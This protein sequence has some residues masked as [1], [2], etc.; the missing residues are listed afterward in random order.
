VQRD[1]RISSDPM[2]HDRFVVPGV[3]E[4]LRTKHARLRAAVARSGSRV[5]CLSCTATAS[6]SQRT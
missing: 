4:A 6:P 1:C 3:A 2:V 5:D